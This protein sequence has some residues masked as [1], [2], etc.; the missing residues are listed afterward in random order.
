MSGLGEAAN[1]STMRS[2]TPR[3]SPAGPAVV[4]GGAERDP[5]IRVEG[6]SKRFG[7]ITAVD[8][9]SFD[10]RPGEVF[11]FLG[12]NGAGK[13]TTIK[14][15]CTLLKPSSGRALIDGHDVVTEAA[16]VRAGIG[17]V[18][19]DNT[20][21]EYLTAEQNLLY[22]AMIYHVPRRE[23]KERILRLLELVELADRRSDV[24]RTFSGGMKRRLEIARAL[25]HLP[26]VLFLDEPTVGLDPQTRHYVWEYLNQVRLQHNVTIFL[27]THYMD[28]AE[29][30]DR[31]AI[32][33]YGRII[34]LD[35]PAALKRMV[36]GDLITL[37]TADDDR[38]RVEIAERL[39]VSGILQRDGHLT[40][41]V[42]SG[43]SFVPRL[44]TALSVPVRTVS[45]R[46]PGLDDVFLRLTGKA[47]RDEEA[48]S[49]ERLKSRMRERG[50][51]RR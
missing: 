11:G 29:N 31:I 33:D 1:G 4:A 45:V 38:A 15:L 47:I 18:F 17:I 21:D 23:R 27:T 50:R 40:F 3:R 49:T 37:S 19:Q 24:V 39:G 42:E 43:E 2:V 22:H 36:G 48:G 44:V 46:R 9:V 28:E 8:G 41:E 13:T 25:L 26:R 32:I 35:T 10:V 12:P 6:L 16:A 7:E 30:A 51:I 5:A 34:A 14:M 20:L